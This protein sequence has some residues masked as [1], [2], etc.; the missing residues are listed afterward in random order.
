[1]E[2]AGVS[3][4]SVGLIKVALSPSL[5]IAWIIIAKVTLHPVAAWSRYEFLQFGFNLKL[6]ISLLLTEYC[7][8]IKLFGCIHSLLTFIFLIFSRPGKIFLLF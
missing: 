8:P 7:L 2:T 4:R 6:R 3:D 1:M 5:N